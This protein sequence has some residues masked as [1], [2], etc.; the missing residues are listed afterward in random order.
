MQ[1][2]DTIPDEQIRTFAARVDGHDIPVERFT[3]LT[4]GVASDIWRVDG[5]TTFCVK[6]ALP[7]LRVAADWF[8]PIERNAKEAAWLR[9]AGSI[10]PTA[11]PRIYLEDAAAGIFAM[12]YFPPA[13]FINWKSRLLAGEADAAIAGQVGHH[14]AA[15]H[16]AAARRTDLAETF[17][18]DATFHAI[19]LEPYLLATAR[20]HPDLAP[21]LENLVERTL[22]N[23]KALVHG[24]ISPKNILVGPKGPVILDAECAW[25]GDPAFDLA[26]CLNHLLL[27]GLTNPRNA[28]GYDA[29]FTALTAAYLPRIDWEDPADLERRAASLLP[30][31]FLARVD[32]KSPVEYLTQDRDKNLVRGVARRFITAPPDHLSVIAQTWAHEL[33]HRIP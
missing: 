25:W 6:R 27:K 3:R 23:K 22:A 4:G 15:I 8:A 5:A 26:F 10:V 28:A 30:A 24:D 12:E 13:D 19:R 17:A 32:G 31:L 7:K 33:Q 21:T 14:M 16:A 29:C 20:A 11:A 9:I 18:T 1:V 2:L